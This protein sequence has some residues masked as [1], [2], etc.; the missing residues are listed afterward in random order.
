MR[1]INVTDFYLLLEEKLNSELL[2]ILSCTS[3]VGHA[4]LI[5]LLFQRLDQVSIEF[6]NI[7]LI[8]I[9]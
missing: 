2:T 1:E 4:L 3:Y 7:L 6:V 9:N 8:I 5:A